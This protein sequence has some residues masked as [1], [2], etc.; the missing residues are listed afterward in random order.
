MSIRVLTT[1][2]ECRLAWEDIWPAKELFDLWDAREC[3]HHSF[4]R[5]LHFVVAEQGNLVIGFLPL[6]WNAETGQYVAFPGET[7]QG[8]T[9]IEQNRIIAASP[10]VMDEMLAAVPGR[11]H[12]RYLTQGAAA[13]SGRQLTEDEI[14]YIFYPGLYGYSYQAYWE[15]FSGKTRKKLS[16]DLKRLESLGLTFRHDRYED[17]EALYAL[18]LEAFGEFSYFSDIRFR[19]GFE[20]LG[21][22]LQ[23][24]GMLKVTTVM[25]SGRIAAVDMGAVYNNTYTLLAGGT[26]P[27]FPG[28]AKVINLHHLARA[29]EKRYD[30][31]DFLCGDFNWK[32]RFRLTERPLHQL[33]HTA[34]SPFASEAYHERAVA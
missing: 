27:E 1:P 28:I 14:G 24:T 34:I 17:M 6:C 9:W 33:T 23:D 30:A 4:S 32:A 15:G 5:P 22:F 26:H 16:A 7:W 25:A 21:K 2:D 20:S 29:C 8:K 13:A 11:V 31:V 3:F 19:N 10:A 12:L 18:N